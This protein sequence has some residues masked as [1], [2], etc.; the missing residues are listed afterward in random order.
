MAESDMNNDILY[1]KKSKG[2]E[3]GILNSS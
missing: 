2:I 3:A 1:E